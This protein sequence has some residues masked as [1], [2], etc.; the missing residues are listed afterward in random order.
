ML[1]F[2]IY[3]FTKVYCYINLILKLFLSC[4]FRF[5]IAD[6]SSHTSAS[7]EIEPFQSKIDI[8]GASGGQLRYPQEYYKGRFRFVSHSVDWENSFDLE[9]RLRDVVTLKRDFGERTENNTIP[10]PDLS[11]FESDGG[12]GD[13]DRK[14]LSQHNP[15]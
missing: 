15:N 14:W 4:Y 11:D 13:I 10:K 3:W 9:S 12:V 1:F 5:K 7:I 2:T 8:V 6:L